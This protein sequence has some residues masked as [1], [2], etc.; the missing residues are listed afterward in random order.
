MGRVKSDVL[1]NVDVKVGR[2]PRGP[3][4]PRGGRGGEIKIRII[5]I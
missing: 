4:V 3:A 1:L 2:W 5:C